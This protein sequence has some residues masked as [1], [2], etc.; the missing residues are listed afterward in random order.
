MAK[1]SLFQSNALRAPKKG[2]LAVAYQ[3]V[4]QEFA[5]IV[6]EKDVKDGDTVSG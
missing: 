1:L 6:C 3:R 2:A 5:K 4:N